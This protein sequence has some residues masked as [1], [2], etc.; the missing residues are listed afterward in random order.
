M[1]KDSSAANKEGYVQ[2]GDGNTHV[3]LIYTK[4][5]RY[6]GHEMSHFPSSVR[7]YL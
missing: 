6:D 2:L 4:G 1:I 3:F 5:Y 7:D